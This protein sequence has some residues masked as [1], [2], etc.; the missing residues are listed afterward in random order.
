[1]SSFMKR[2]SSGQV[3]WVMGVGCLIVSAFSAGADTFYVDSRTGHDGAGGLSPS[4][5]WRTLEKASGRTYRAGDRLLLRRGSVFSGTL[6][7]HALGSAA[8]PV[9]VDCYGREDD[10]LPLVDGAG[11][12][13]GVHVAESRYVEISRLEITADAGDVKEP[14]A[15]DQRYGVLATV[16]EDAQLAHV[17]LR[18]LFIH[19]IFATRQKV[20]DGRHPTSNMGMGIQFLS[21]GGRGRFSDILIE[22]CRIERTGHTG[23][24][25]TSLNK[26]AAGFNDGIRV[27]ANTLKDI[28]GPGIQPSRGKNI[29]VRDNVVDGSGSSVDP[30]MHGRGSGIWPWTCHDVLIE[31][32]RF[33]HARGKADS[34]GAHIDFN[35]TDVVVQYNLSLDNEGGFIE[36]LG[37]TRNCA[38][39]YNIS[40]NDG[41]RVKG[42][43]GAHQDGKVLWL[44]GYTGKNQPRHGPFDSYVYNNTVYVKQ[45]ARSCFAVAHTTDGLFVANNIFHVLGETVNV[46]GDQVNRLD[47]KGATVKDIVFKNNLYPRAGTVPAT[48]P[49]QDSGALIGEP[50]LRNPGGLEPADYIPGNAVVVK[51]RGVPVTPVPGDAVGLKIGLNVEHDFF[52]NP[53]TGLPD[54]GAVELQD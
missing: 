32:N 15:R 36:I 52:G 3:L 30:R 5:A 50:R 54:L 7:L 4:E 1:M 46:Y 21:K 2:I 38:Y 9:I 16:S 44:S 49:I 31:N 22:D 28:G 27:L 13:A 39:R 26:D 11:H 34:C 6:K 51:D 45:G 20:S 8:A 40:I 43:N 53:I 48:L 12:L 47:P 10:A 14:S 37:N 29:V 42:K 19:N 18:Q 33:M 41:F 23:I 24:K 35:C 25:I 17:Y